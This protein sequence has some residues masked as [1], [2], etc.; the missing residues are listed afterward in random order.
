MEVVQHVE[1]NHPAK[2][3]EEDG[4]AGACESCHMLG[5]VH[6]VRTLQ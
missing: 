2:E 1:K 4:C 5:Q 3:V 6:A